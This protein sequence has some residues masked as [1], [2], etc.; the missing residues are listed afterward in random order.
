M[1]TPSWR[2]F[3]VYTP[4]NT[5][6]GVLSGHNAARSGARVSQVPR[7]S[8]PFWLAYLIP[9]AGM[10]RVEERDALTKLHGTRANTVSWSTPLGWLESPLAWGGL[11]A[12][13]YPTICMQCCCCFLCAS[14]FRHLAARTQ[15]GFEFT[16]TRILLSWNFILY[17]RRG[18]LNMHTRY[19]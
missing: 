2:R 7:G 4:A 11:Y 3:G 9:S 18:T 5:R 10:R 15:S 17:R 1:H 13:R 16:C 6:L 12:T 14:T 8:G 19:E